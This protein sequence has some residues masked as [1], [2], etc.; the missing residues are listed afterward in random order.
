MWRFL[1]SDNHR[2]KSFC[3]AFHAVNLTP[4]QPQPQFQ[5]IPYKAAK[6]ANLLYDWVPNVFERHV[7]VADNQFS[8]EHRS[9]IQRDIWWQFD[10]KY[11]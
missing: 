2:N 10:T 5:S 11:R 9:I 4:A 6:L 3:A 8:A 7:D 1:K